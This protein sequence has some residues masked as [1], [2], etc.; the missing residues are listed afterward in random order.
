MTKTFIV[1]P[2][3]NESASIPT[4][5]TDLKNHN[6]HN[7][8]VV[9]DGSKDATSTLSQSSGATVITHHVNRGQGADII[10]HFDAD[11]QMRAQDITKVITPLLEGNADISFGSRFVK[12]TSNIPAFRKTILILGRV[13]MRILFKV[14][15]KDPQ[16]G[17]RALTRKA[18]E[19][20]EIQQRGMTHCS[21]ILEQTHKKNLRFVEVPVQILYTDYSKKKG[22]SNLEALRIATK[23]LWSKLMR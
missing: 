6:Y 9:D 14:K 18:A 11:G 12:N 4:V 16:S 5:I 10:V 7:I 20:I 15:T 2:A 23:L 3:H 17:F 13:F 22:Q 1:I 21:E 19:T 8:I